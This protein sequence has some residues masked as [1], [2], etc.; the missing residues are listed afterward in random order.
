[1]G[2]KNSDNKPIMKGLLNAFTLNRDEKELVPPSEPVKERNNKK[3]PEKK[4]EDVVPE[5]AAA[6]DPQPQEN[7]LTCITEGVVIN[8]SIES[9]NDLLIQGVINGDVVC[10]GAVTMTGAISGKVE[11][12][13]FVLDGGVLE[14]SIKSVTVAEIYEGRVKGDILASDIVITGVVEGNINAGNF[15]KI[16]N[17]GSITG[18]ISTR[19]IFVS[20]DSLICGNIACR[21]G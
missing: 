18:D 15:C 11:A 14:G 21:R 9:K 10:K 8:G 20:E 1:M 4:V 2:Q 13:S 17:G 3:I 6:V 12:N 7:P 19:S 5:V 16:F